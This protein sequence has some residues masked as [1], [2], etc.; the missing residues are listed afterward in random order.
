V[1][2]VGAARAGAGSYLAESAAQRPVAVAWRDGWPLVVVLA[3]SLLLLSLLPTGRLILAALTRAGAFAPDAALAEIVSRAALRALANSLET[4]IASAL[5]AVVLGLGAALAVT[6][7]DVRG[8]GLFSFLFVLSMMM[9][10]QVVALA[11]ITATGP[12]SPFLQT[13][14]LAPPP[15]TPNPLRGPGGIVA[16]LA[17]HHAPLAFVTLRAGLRRIPRD[18]VDAASIDGASRTAVILRI[19]LPLLRGHLIAAGVLCFVAAIGNFGIPALLGLPVNYLTLPTLIYRR[20]S[21][22]GPAVI[23]DAAAVSLLLIVLAGIGLLVSRWLAASEHARLEPGAGL[24][25]LWPAGRRLGLGLQGAMAL[26]V[27]VTLAVP[28]LSLLTAALVPTYGVG[29]SLQTLT[30]DNFVEVL[31]RQSATARAFWNSF[32]FSGIAAL[33][34]ALLALPLGYVLARRAGRWRALIEGSFEVPYALPGVVLALACILLFLRPLPVVEISLYG[35][36][37]IIIF[38]YVARFLPLALKPVT[39]ALAQL[40]PSVEEAASVCGATVGQRLR[41]I[42]APAAAPAMAA[43]ALLAFL[44]AFNELTVSALLWSRGT[45]T[46]GVVLFSLEE[47]GLVSAAAAVALASVAVI[48]LVML[49]LDRLAGRLPEDVLPWR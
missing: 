32:V 43:G 40:D 12:S 19:V 13:L 45:E 2:E 27:V 35:T 24:D 23:G 29:L 10:P 1:S 36:P 14:G 30:F 34:V 26:V 44:I 39:A 9:A 17:L 21:S 11:F 18:L 22:L 42:L 31:M 7:T 28:L 41:H 3:A 25:G 46:L 5:L 47:A 37:V 15:G 4:G 8:K 16:V 49:A 33:I 20:L 48:T 6:L 38:A